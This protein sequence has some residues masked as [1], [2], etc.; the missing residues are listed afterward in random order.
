MKL[1]DMP[2]Y[3]S[4]YLRPRDLQGRSVRVQIRQVSVASTGLALPYTCSITIELISLA[5]S[6]K[7]S[8]T[9]SRCL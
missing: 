2:A 9:F 1:R 6:S 4:K 8:E 3:Q 5:T 7:R